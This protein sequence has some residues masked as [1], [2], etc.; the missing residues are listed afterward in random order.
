MTVSLSAPYPGQRDA[1]E[2]VALLAERLPEPLQVLASLA[3]NYRWSW[4][5]GGAEVF[6]DIDPALWERS[7][8]NPRAVVELA[9]PRRLRQLAADASYRERIAVLA[10]DVDADLRRP[11]EAHGVAA[12]RPVAYFC[13]EFGVH[14]SL[15]IY[16]GGLG[17]LAGDVLKAASDL[18]LPMVGVGLLYREGYF[19][20]RLDS[21]GGST[22]SG[23]KTT[24]SD[25]RRSLV[26]GTDDRPVTVTIVIRN[27]PCHPGVAGRRR[28]R[29]ALPARHRSGGQPPHRPLHHRPAVHRRPAHALGA[30]RGARHRRHACCWPRSAFDPA[31]SISTKATRRS[32]RSSACASSCSPATRREEAIGTVRAATVF[33]THTPVAAGNEG[34]TFDEVEPVLGELR[35]GLDEDRAVLLRPRPVRCRRR[36]RGGRHHAAGAAHQPGG[37]RRV[38]PPRRGRARDVAAALAGANAGRRADRPRDQWRAHHDLDGRVRCRPCSIGTRAPTGAARLGDGRLWKRIGAI[39]DAELWEVRSEL[40]R[41]LVEYARTRSIAIGWPAARRPDY[42]EAAARVF[43]PDVLTIGFARRVAT[44]KRLHLLTQRLDRGLRLLANDARPI[45]VVIAGKAHPQDQ[46][47]KAGAASGRSSCGA[48]PTSGSRI[49]FLEDYDLHMAPRLVSGRRPVAQHAAAAARSERH[50]RHEGGAQRRA[51]P[52]RPRRL[53]DGGLRRR[54]RLGDRQ[55]GGDAAAQDEHD[56]AALLRT[57]RDEVIPLFYERDAAGLPRR[58]IER[59]KVSMQRLIPRFNAERMVREYVTALYVPPPAG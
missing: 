24:S 28:P 9:S 4:I 37:D 47:A 34:Y 51:Q 52:E 40:R 13:S 36:T 38:A 50:E 56:A 19:H 7:H 43:D 42:V 46:E 45:Q 32:P 2:A 58:W 30:V 25:C 39:S 20:Q 23:R 18:A 48:T 8:C 57:A 35:D 54:D 44:Y 53:V 15:P 55:P 31:S 33:T 29:A 22:N 16:G 3:F 59:I 26:T 5:A 21:T 12:D 10:A 17:V 6:A 41:Q 11:A 1:M 27:R 49:V 14:G